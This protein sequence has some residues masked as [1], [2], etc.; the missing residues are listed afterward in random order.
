MPSPAYS[1]PKDQRKSYYPNMVIIC[2]LS[3]VI[4][5]IDFKSRNKITLGNLCKGYC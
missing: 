2:S 4:I 5:E 1:G 3:W